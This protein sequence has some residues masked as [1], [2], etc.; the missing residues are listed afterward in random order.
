MVIALWASSMPSSMLM[1]ITCAP[2]STCCR[3]TS[4]AVGQSPLR[5]SLAKAFGAGDVGTFADVDEQ[6]AV[7]DVERLQPR[8][9]A[10]RFD[11]RQRARRD[12]RYCL[13]YCGNVIRRGAAAAAD[14]VD[15]AGSARITAPCR[16]GQIVAAEFVRQT[17]VS[18]HR[19]K[20]S[21]TRAPFL[22]HRAQQIRAKRAVEAEANGAA[23]RSEL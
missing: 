19:H 15:Q 12:G 7:T 6:I 17:G 22:P 21:P 5:I 23:W 16:R 13:R 10:F 9:A 2:F 4:S 14:D 11:L 8:Q 20:G 3:A 18:V 1:S